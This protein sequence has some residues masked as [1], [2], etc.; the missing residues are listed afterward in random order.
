MMEK[1]LI[2]IGRQELRLE[3]LILKRINTAEIEIRKAASEDAADIVQNV[4]SVENPS[5][6]GND[7]YSAASFKNLI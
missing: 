3:K 2:D 6:S 5:G 4:L 1:S 7:P